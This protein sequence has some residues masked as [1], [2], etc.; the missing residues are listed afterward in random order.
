MSFLT[1]QNSVK[2]LFFWVA[3]SGL[4]YATE[5]EKLEMEPVRAQ[6][7]P[8]H[9]VT[10]SSEL[11]GRVEGLP[12]R[13]GE[14]FNKGDMLFSIDCTMHRARLLKAQAQLAE[15]RKINEV[16]SNLDR[17]G[18]ISTLEIE[19]SKARLGAASAELKIMKSMVERCVIP[20]PFSG[21]VVQSFAVRHQYVA[22][23]QPM[24]EIIDDGALEIETLVPSTWLSWL[25]IEQPFD[26]AID[27]SGRRL[28]AKISRISPVID[29]LS[30][31]VKIFG[32]LDVPYKSL[33]PG[34]SGV[35]IFAK[36]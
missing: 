22:E 26:V 6:L 25:D 1:K 18:S 15:F 7:V 9:N 16:N 12:Q 29:P 8:R 3:F 21:K 2:S 10:L 23:G 30:S 14:S 33:V 4:S 11:S 20:A 27:E 34:M 32:R 24:L 35:A 28:S 36:P 31:S 13:E 5:V 19:V 17:L